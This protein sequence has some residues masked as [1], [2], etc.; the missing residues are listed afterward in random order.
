MV[1]GCY[2]IGADL[3]CSMRKQDEEIPGF[4]AHDYHAAKK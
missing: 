1:V 2:A 4:R 3:R